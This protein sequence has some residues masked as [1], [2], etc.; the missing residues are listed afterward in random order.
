MRSV[1]TAA[2]SCHDPSLSHPAAP[3]CRR[4]CLIMYPYPPAPFVAPR[5]G[6]VCP[7]LV[8]AG[9]VNPCNS[10]A[11]WI[12]SR[13]GLLG[14]RQTHSS[15]HGTAVTSSLS[16]TQGWQLHQL[17]TSAQPG[18]AARGPGQQKGS[19]VVSGWSRRE[20][21]GTAPGSVHAQPCRCSHRARHRSLRAR[22]SAP[23]RR[24]P[25][26]SG[27]GRCRGTCRGGRAC[28]PRSCRGR[29]KLA[30]KPS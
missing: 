7:A 16:S 1:Q 17:K 10:P 27:P 26:S 14:C 6:I 21:G 11:P 19:D 24:R 20:P 29:R 23:G 5:S 30:S 13:Y 3:P 25:R 2:S 9:A 18:S 28:A 4:V 8:D 22:S 15:A 12:C